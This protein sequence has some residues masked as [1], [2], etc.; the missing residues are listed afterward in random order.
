[1]TK[2]KKIILLINIIAITILTIAVLLNNTAILDEWIFKSLHS[3]TNGKYIDFFKTFTELGSTKGILITALL[4][5]II[6]FKKGGINNTINI[7]A[8]AL[9]NQS[10]K[11]I[12][13]RPRP[14]WKIIEQ[15]GYSYPSGHSM[16]TFCLYGYLIFLAHKH[17]KEKWLR[18]TIYITCS[19]IIFLI[20]LSR[21]YLGVHY[22]SDVIGG[23]LITFAFLLVITS[24]ETQKDKN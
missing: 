16:A 13:K 2:T 19:L 4:I 9:I 17:I 22:A 6:L 5:L 8:I 20:G 12:I 7:V 14:T 10:S 1:M 24:L 11:F 3:M 21:I 18:I 15:A 23:Y